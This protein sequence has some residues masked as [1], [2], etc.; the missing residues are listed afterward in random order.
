ME[1]LH[2]GYEDVMSMPVGR[3]RR[4]IEE[5]EHIVAIAKKKRQNR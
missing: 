3:R 2:Q 5:R 4:I 1:F